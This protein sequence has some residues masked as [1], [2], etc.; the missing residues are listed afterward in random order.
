MFRIPILGP[1]SG[2][3]IAN[4]EITNQQILVHIKSSKVQKVCYVSCFCGSTVYQKLCLLT[5]GY[6]VLAFRK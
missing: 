5:E 2:T 1:L 3:R 4:H 6:D